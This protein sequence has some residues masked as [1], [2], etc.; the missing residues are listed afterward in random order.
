LEPLPAIVIDSFNECNFSGSFA[1][2]LQN[3]RKMG[4]YRES[5]PDQ[6]FSRQ[7]ATLA[8]DLK[9]LRSHKRGIERTYGN[10]RQGSLPRSDGGIGREQRANEMSQAKAVFVPSEYAETP[11]FS[12]SSRLTFRAG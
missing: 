9:K 1:E 3:R 8:P 6:R 7:F 11:H 12:A 10:N 2:E 4:T 5:R